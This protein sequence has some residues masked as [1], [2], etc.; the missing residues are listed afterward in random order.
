MDNSSRELR[1]SFARYVLDYRKPIGLLLAVV[2]IFMAYWAVHLPIATHFEDLFPATHPNTVLYRQFRRQYGGAQTLVLMVRVKKGDIYNFKTLHDIQDITNEVDRIPGVN[3]NEVFSLSSYRILFAQAL[4]GALVSTP[5]MY[6]KVPTTQAQIDALKN[7]VLANGE[8]LAGFVTRDQ[9]GALIV[10]SFNEQGLDY[11]TL[12]DS[13]QDTIRKHQ[14]A[15]TRIYV[16]GAVMFSA[17][18]YHY[19]PRI[20]KIFVLSTALMLLILYL[21]LGRYSGWWAP[22]LTGILSAIWGLGFVSLMGFNFDPIMLVIPFIMTARDLGHGIQWQGRYYDELD[23]TKDKI[24]ACVATADLMLVPGILAILANIAGIIFI[25][26]GNIPVLR[27]IGIGGAVWMGASVAMVFVFQ[28]ILISYLPRPE[29]RE[30]S[31]LNKLANSG[32]IVRLRNFADQLVMAAITRGTARTVLLGVGVLALIVGIAAERSVSIGYQTAGTPIYTADSK[33]NQDTAEISKFVPT[34]IGWIVL[35][36]PEF[37]SSQS[38]VG[39]DT[40]RMSDDLANYLMSRGD[41][42]AVLGFSALASKP[43][44]MLLHNGEPKYYAL[45]DSNSLSAS[46]W[47]F[48]FAATAPGEAES[49]FAISQ[50]MRNSCIRV[51]LQDHTYARLKRLRHDIDSFIRERVA[52][53]PGLN[54]VKLRYIGGEAGLYLASDDVIGRLN[55]VNLSLTLVA[56]LLACAVVFRSLVAGLFFALSCIAA[57][58]IAFAYMNV[59]NIGLTVD[60]LPVI[61]LGI[62]LG[63]DYGIYTVMRIR[64]EVIGG[65]TLKDAITKGL[66][67]TGAWV[68]CTFAVMVGGIFAW[69]FSPL[70]FHS[71]MSVLLILLMSTNLIAGLL[72]LPALIAWRQPRFLSRY[73]NTGQVSGFDAK[74]P[75]MSGGF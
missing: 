64:D 58:F 15:N 49:Y 13:V 59:Y 60:T 16:S 71:E 46:L 3:H 26:I 38:G 21:S 67:T 11:K 61:S 1:R 2:T 74:R 33:I 47:G 65:L 31:F 62:G 44:N 17:W 56:I 52:A 9:K 41:V 34:N 40:L 23:R 28:P 53:D 50:S 4:P 66:R 75:G 36:T 55:V 30:R 48:F 18:G 8:Q 57:N 63:V 37:P 35:E 45:P 39:I 70:L 29:F 69:V 51:L 42:V 10:A 12:F 73:E 20:Q 19:L 14:D 24:E 27:Q 43:M 5:F 22:M 6:P 68:F 72:L 25:V 32:L 7:N 54:Q